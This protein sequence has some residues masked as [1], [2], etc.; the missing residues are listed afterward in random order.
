MQR[1][2]NMG[3]L[4]QAYA[5]KKTLEFFGCKVE[6]LDIRKIEK[7]CALLGNYTEDY[8]ESER[9]GFA[10]KLKKLNRYSINRFKN[11]HTSYK[12]DEYF[13]SFRT[14]QLCIEK[15]SSH[16]DLC[17]IGSDEV[18][19]CLNSGA[20]GFTSQLFGN[21]P[22]A[23]RVITYAASCGATKYDNLT[24]PIRHKISESFENIACFSVRDENTYTFVRNLAPK[25]VKIHLDPVLIYDFQ[26]ELNDVSVEFPKK[27]CIVYSY[28]NRMHDKREVENVVKF[29]KDNGLTPI[30][31]G[32]PQYWIK[33]Y[34][35]CTPFECLKYFQNA[36]FVITD[37]FHGTIFAAKYSK[38]FGVLTR[39]SNY[40]K[41]SDLVERLGIQNHLMN[42]I[43][44]LESKYKMPK[45]D[46]SEIIQVERERTLDYLRQYC[47]E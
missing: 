28:Y 3:S 32:A 10:G 15:K 36:E 16:Y 22:E 23:K 33:E 2:D 1:I 20:W 29:C 31:L 25:D 8:Q 9:T 30:A 17:I 38:A 18:F 44:E 19:N 45:T 37:T 6:F 43:Y 4:L 41:L 7:D 39:P 27:Y 40:N 12:Q 5:L 24:L 46:I 47:K 13:G 11:K 42:S 34:I 14:S 35:P 21:V 26:K